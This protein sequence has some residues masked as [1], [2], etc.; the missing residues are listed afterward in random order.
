MTN[1]TQTSFE[2]PAPNRKKIEAEFSGIEQLLVSYLRPSNIDGAKHAWAI[3]AFVAGE[4][5]VGTTN[6]MLNTSL[7]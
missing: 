4:C 6:T 2:S 1:S 3:V 5:C 7:V